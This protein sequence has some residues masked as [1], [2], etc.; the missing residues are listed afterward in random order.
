LRDFDEGVFRVDELIEKSGINILRTIDG[1]VP[2]NHEKILCEGW[3][4]PVLLN[5]LSVLLV[6]KVNFA[7]YE[8][9]TIT[10]EYI[11]KNH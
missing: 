11:R 1:E 4:R 2:G 9:K 3:T 7:T 5:N 10:K 6:E 8:W